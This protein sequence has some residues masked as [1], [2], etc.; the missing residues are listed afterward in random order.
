V[1]VKQLV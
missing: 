1:F